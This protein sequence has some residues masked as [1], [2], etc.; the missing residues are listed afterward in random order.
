MTMKR[1]LIKL[2][3]LDLIS[4]LLFCGN[5]ASA[6][7]LSMPKYLVHSGGSV[8]IPIELDDATGLAS[9]DLQINFNPEYLILDDVVAGQ[10]GEQ[11][12]MIHSEDNGILKFSFVR[13][14]NLVSGTGRLA[15]LNFRMKAG[16]PM[17]LTSPVAIATYSLGNSSGV[18]A[19]QRKDSIL[20]NNGQIEV[21][22]STDI[23]NFGNGLPDWWEEQ[24]GLD[25]FSMSSMDADKDG[26]D[27]LSEFIAGTNPTNGTSL[28]AIHT[29]DHDPS[30]FIIHWNAVSGRVYAVDWTDSLTNT[31][32]DLATNIYYPQNSYT[33]TVHS[34]DD[35]GFY[36]IDVKLEN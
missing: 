30:G 32:L 15:V 22:N 8:L 17:G 12:T 14:A 1:I 10:L 33:D 36:S 29:T 18:V 19:L 13:G 31:F 11:F 26:M 34:A 35:E 6:L 27:A 3:Y 9:I 2:R 4:L 7:Q 28:F 21:S 24:Y 16:A 20:V 5:I 25:L 23:D